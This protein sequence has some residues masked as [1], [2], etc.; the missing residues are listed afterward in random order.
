MHRAITQL[1]PQGGRVAKS[2][3][4]EKDAK[5]AQD[6]VPQ[7]DDEL[8]LGSLIIEVGIR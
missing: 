6:I 4:I 8:S 1:L 2:V 7:F 5:P 3:E